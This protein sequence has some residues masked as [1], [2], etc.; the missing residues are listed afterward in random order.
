MKVDK[1]PLFWFGC[2][3]SPS[4]QKCE[5]NFEEAIKNSV[6]LS[7]LYMKIEKLINQYNKLKLKS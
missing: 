2:L 1:N 4:L 7:N 5:N 3:S 6:E